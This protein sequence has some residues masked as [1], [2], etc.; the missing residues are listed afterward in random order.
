[1]NQEQQVNKM[2]Q[3]IARCWAD[4]SFKQQL[5]TDPAA[6][7]KAEGVDVPVGMNVRV[8]ENTQ[9]LFHLVLPP[10]PAELSDADL[11][12]VAGGFR[13]IMDGKILD[14]NVYMRPERPQRNYVIRAWQVL[15]GA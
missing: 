6:V 2:N 10:R 15:T 9:Q 7:L 5:L 12:A 8:V 11:D 3:L 1:M 14:V 13:V 4:E